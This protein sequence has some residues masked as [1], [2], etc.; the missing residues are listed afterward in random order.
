MV[1]TC[2]QFGECDSPFRHR[3]RGNWQY[4]TKSSAPNTKDSQSIVVRSEHDDVWSRMAA[5][6]KHHRRLGEGGLSMSRSYDR[7]LP[8]I[9]ATL[10]LESQVPR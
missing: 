3:L 4:T 9:H 7:P 10:C 1:T 8:L 5:S 6:Y 2:D